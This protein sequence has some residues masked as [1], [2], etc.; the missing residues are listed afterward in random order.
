M[1][2]RDRQYERFI[3]MFEALA[4]WAR[5]EQPELPPLAPLNAR[6]IVFS[7][8]ELVAEH[9]RTGH[10]GEL[11]ALYGDLLELIVLLLADEA[12]ARAARGPAEQKA[13]HRA[14]DA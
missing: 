9:V 4:A 5:R 13:T 14:S 11:S 2:Q 1:E 10:G 7:V 6:V 12:T 8:T 3:E